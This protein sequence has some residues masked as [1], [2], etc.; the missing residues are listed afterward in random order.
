MGNSVATYLSVGNDGQ[1]ESSGQLQ[2]GAIVMGLDGE[3]AQIPIIIGVM[4]VKI[5]RDMETKQLLSL[6]RRWNLCVSVLTMSPAI[7]RVWQ[8]QKDIIEQRKDIT[9]DLPSPKGDKNSAVFLVW[10]SNNSGTNLNR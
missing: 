7:Y 10:F 5:R 6:V 2:P 9:I 4:Q 8:L 1:G 3:N